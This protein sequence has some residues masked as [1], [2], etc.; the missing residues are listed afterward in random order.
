M[1]G[2]FFPFSHQLDKLLS[3]HIT[4]EQARIWKCPLVSPRNAV[5]PSTSNVLLSCLFF[6]YV[7]DRETS[8]MALVE[9]EMLSGFIPV[10]RAVKEVRLWPSLED[11]KIY[12]PD[13]AQP[14]IPKPLRTAGEW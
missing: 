11:M 14:E 1:G 12:F 7:G 10:K 4:V 13:V 3:F 8:N 5:I 2:Y 9:V 6:S